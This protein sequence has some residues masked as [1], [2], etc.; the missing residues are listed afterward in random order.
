MGNR[1]CPLRYCLGYSSYILN[2]AGA[3]D[4]VPPDPDYDLRTVW[5]GLGDGRHIYISPA[6]RAGEAARKQWQREAR[7]GE[8]TTSKSWKMSFLYWY[9]TQVPSRHL[10]IHVACL[11]PAFMTPS[12]N[13]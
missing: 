6:P 2:R 9:E 13:S 4:R 12:S 5:M 3:T 8:G 1:D 11:R 10:A 7:G